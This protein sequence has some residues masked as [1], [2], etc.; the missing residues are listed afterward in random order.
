M[1]WILYF[2]TVFGAVFMDPA[3]RREDEWRGRM[4]SQVLLAG[5]GACG[6]RFMVLVVCALGEVS[7]A[8]KN[9]SA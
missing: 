1:T 5:R 6:G 8:G 4:E 9:D 7:V 3:R 2:G